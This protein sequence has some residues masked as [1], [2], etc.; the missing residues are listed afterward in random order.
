[1][2]VW[3]ITI[4]QTAG[5]LFKN[6]PQKIDLLH[7]MELIYFLKTNFKNKKWNR[8]ILRIH[9]FHKPKTS[10]FFEIHF[11]LRLNWRF[12]EKQHWFQQ[13]VFKSYI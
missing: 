8:S 3:L 11:F 5:F 10:Q 9:D 1:M 12:L 2:E 4:Q 13:Q 7:A 6:Q